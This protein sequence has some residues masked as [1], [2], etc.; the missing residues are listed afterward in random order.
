MQKCSQLF[1]SRAHTYRE[2]GIENYQKGEDGKPATASAPPSVSRSGIRL[3]GHKATGGM[4]KQ[5]NRL[6]DR[7]SSAAEMKPRHRRSELW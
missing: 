4:P 6:E 1:R 3:R 5:R 7:R 2:S